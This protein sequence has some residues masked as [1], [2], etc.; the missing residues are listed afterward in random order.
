MKAKKINEYSKNGRVVKVYEITSATPEQLHLY[1]E[2]QGDYYR[3]NEE[4]QRPLFF[5]R[6]DFA[7]NELELQFNRDKT[8]VYV[9]NNSVQKIMSATERLGN[10]TLGNAFAQLS[11]QHLFAQLTGV[12]VPSTVAV[13]EPSAVASAVAMPEANP[14]TEESGE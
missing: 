4:N 3:V 7:P 6:E 5:Y 9:A 14:F 2:I 1:A 10:T 11:A 12:S 13:A 8:G